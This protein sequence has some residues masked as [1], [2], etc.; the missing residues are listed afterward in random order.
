MNVS[1]SAISPLLVTGSWN[2]D[3]YM[4]GTA[5]SHVVAVTTP[6]TGQIYSNVSTT[7]TNSTAGTLIVIPDGTLY[8]GTKL[9]RLNKNV[10]TPANWTY[11]IASGT[12]QFET[13]LK[14]Y[15]LYRLNAGGVPFG[16]K[17]QSG[18]DGAAFWNYSTWSSVIFTITGEDLS[19]TSTPGTTILEDHFYLYL[20]TTNYTGVTWSMVTNATWLSQYPNG[21]VYGTPSNLFANQ[22]FWVNVTVTLQWQSDY[23]NFSLTATNVAP[24]ITTSPDSW[25]YIEVEFQ[26]TASFDDLAAG[27]QFIGVTTN[28]TGEYDL[29][30]TTGL[31]TFRSYETGTWYFNITFNDMTGAANATGYQYFVVEVIS[32]GPTSTMSII[33]LLLA[34]AFGFGFLIVGFKLH[35]L[36]ILAG[37][38]WI[39]AGL[40]IFI[41]F[42]G[43]FL[44]VIGITSVG[45]GI[46]LM[47][48]GVSPY[49]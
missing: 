41:P 32:G 33:M 30:L 8:G 27:G 38:I 16:S 42:G 39:V 45:L 25:V 5:S 10:A 24:L 23:Q 17:V 21:T 35:E 34:L 15:S 19:I 26:Y 28:F 43:V 14:T 13:V 29:D 20:P 40:T 6:M 49:L 7:Y 18:A 2:G 9:I 48:K 11:T 44:Y 4:N 31:F 47:F 3:I 12:V 36:W 1:G 37:I 22:V 46:V